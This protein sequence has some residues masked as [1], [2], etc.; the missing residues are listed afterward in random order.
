MATGIES[1]WLSGTFL[2][3]IRCISLHKKRLKTESIRI[4]IHWHCKPKYL[5]TTAEIGL[6]WPRTPGVSFRQNCW[7]NS[8][9]RVSEGCACCRLQRSQKISEARVIWTPRFSMFGQCSHCIDSILGYDCNRWP[10]SIKYHHCSI[11]YPWY[12]HHLSI[13]F[14]NLEVLG[15][16]RHRS[17]VP[18]AGSCAVSAR[19]S[20][21]VDQFYKGRRTW[22]L[23]W[24]A[25]DS[26][27]AEGAQIG[28]QTSKSTYST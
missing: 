19:Y 4:P 24:S 18:N 22:D 10:W 17:I 15:I 16:F 14:Q 6:A 21:D 2:E 5:E 1:S 9:Q 7:C 25:P 11:I 28:T 13:S 26:C 20:T 27:D 3:K 12:F 8:A 23:L